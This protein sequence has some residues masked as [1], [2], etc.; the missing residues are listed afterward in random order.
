VWPVEHGTFA[1]AFLRYGLHQ[2]VQ[3][4]SKGMF[5]V[6]D[7]FDYHRLPEVFAGHPRDEQHPFPALYP[8]TNWPQA[9][10]ASAVFTMT[11]AL[12]GIYPYAPLHT[13]LLDPHL[14][15]WLPEI[16]VD[17][18]HVG[19]AVAKI[20]FF[21]KESGESDF[22]VLEV[23]GKLHIVRQP[24]PWSVTATWTERV[25]DL[26]SSLVRRAA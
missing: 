18:L 6:A 16:V 25:H 26:I 8:Q 22:E 7:L 2:H 10:S 14:P 11:Q 21:R 5:D 13:L 19:N 1:L 17:N 23:R 15:D 20:R 12:L 9:W 4:I 3:L 24:S